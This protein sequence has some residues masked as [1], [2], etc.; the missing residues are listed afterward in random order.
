LRCKTSRREGSSARTNP[1]PSP[2]SSARAASRQVCVVYLI[3]INNIYIYIYVWLA[4]VL[5]ASI[6]GSLRA[7]FV[8][9][10][11]GAGSC[12]AFRVLYMLNLPCLLALLVALLALLVASAASPAPRCGRHLEGPL[13]PAL[14]PMLLLLLHA[15]RSQ[16]FNVTLLGF[17]CFVRI[18]RDH[19]SCVSC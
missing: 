3:P 10:R 11:S 5:L 6:I 16:G 9:E 17:I 18:A 8:T 7:W 1:P 2:A 15:S 12:R 13:L 14:L 19:F 4:A